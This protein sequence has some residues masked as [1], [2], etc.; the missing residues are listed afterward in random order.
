M[1]KKDDYITDIFQIKQRLVTA[2]VKEQDN[3]AIQSIKDYFKESYP[4]EYV[5]IA[6]LDENKVNEII[7]LGIAEYQRRHNK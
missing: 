5:N 6:F 7:K 4:N 2:I 1:S 3:L